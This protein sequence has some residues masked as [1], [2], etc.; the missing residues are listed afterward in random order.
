MI[1]A[2][3]IERG[4]GRPPDG[5]YRCADGSIVP[6]VTTVLQWWG[7]RDGLERWAAREAVNARDA[8]ARKWDAIRAHEGVRDAAGDHG[9]FVHRAVEATL[10]GDPVDLP[11]DDDEAVA[12]MVA[13]ERALDWLA[14]SGEAQY[15]VPAGFEVRLADPDLGVGGTCDYPW[16]YRP[17]L[18]ER[19]GR[20]IG[21]LK[22]GTVTVSV[23]AQLGLYSELWER[24][25]DEP[26]VA[27]FSLRVSR[28]DESA[29]EPVW[30]EGRDLRHARALGRHILAAWQIEQ[31][32]AR[33]FGR[34]P[35]K[36]EIAA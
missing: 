14:S 13:V 22:T 23:A 35:W 25:R 18:E 1:E 30:L 17:P 15:L 6:S 32:L 2:A 11:D 8:G 21:D 9:S 3:E 34:R 20:V 10:C 26:V 27:A 12:V 36:P 5:I 24:Q 31:R 29:P 4:E 16:L 7:K 28:K 19:H 33:R